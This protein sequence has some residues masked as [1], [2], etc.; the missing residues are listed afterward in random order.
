MAR[1]RRKRSMRILDWNPTP[2]HEVPY[3]PARPGGGGTNAEPLAT[4]TGKGSGL[5][6]P[7]D[8]LVFPAALQG[9]EQLPPTNRQRRA[10]TWPP[11]EGRR[12][13]GEVAAE[14][15]RRLCERGD[16]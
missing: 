1:R 14:H 4:P 7:P 6:E 13:L 9:R 2:L 5:P 11:R 8:G 10:G 3:L 12:L 15:L 16:L